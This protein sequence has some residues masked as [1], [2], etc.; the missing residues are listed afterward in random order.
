[1][2]KSV[3]ELNSSI[4]IFLLGDKMRGI[5][6]EIREYRAGGKEKKKKKKIRIPKNSFI[7]M[8][9]LV[10]YFVK[11][12]YMDGLEERLTKVYNR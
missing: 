11:Y 4:R 7:R 12:I 10:E 9:F 3:L 2:N 1:M 6:D 8:L 5:Y